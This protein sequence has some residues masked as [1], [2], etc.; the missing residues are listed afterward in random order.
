VERRAVKVL[1]NS[2]D[3]PLPLNEG[4]WSNRESLRIARN[5]CC[6]KKILF[7]DLALNKYSLEHEEVCNSPLTYR[8][9]LRC[10][11][12]EAKLTEKP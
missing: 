9:N 7:M 11:K 2:R 3:E 6:L 5:E 10:G 12:Q 1:K 4:E 8:L